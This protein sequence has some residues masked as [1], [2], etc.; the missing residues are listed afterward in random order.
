MKE[1]PAYALASHGICKECGITFRTGTGVGLRRFLNSTDVPVLATND[2]AR[3]L[4]ANTA[5]LSALGKTAEAIQN[6]HA[7]VII[8]CGRL[9][10][11]CGQSADCSSCKLREAIRATHRDG[12][13]RNG[14][15]STHSFKSNKLSEKLRFAFSTAKMGDVVVLAIEGREIVS[16]L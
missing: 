16:D 10:E 9:G 15:V 2:D 1:D 14:L 3:V 13:A 12:R 8:E 5:A 4:S 11:G 6:Q 7:G